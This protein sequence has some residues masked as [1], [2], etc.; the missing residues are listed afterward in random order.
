MKGKIKMKNIFQIIVESQKEN[1]E[2][3]K[4]NS[5][6]KNF[7][8]YKEYCENHIENVKKSFDFLK[9]NVPEI[10]QGLDL[11]LLEKNISEHDSSKFSEKE[12][13]GY[14]NKF[15]GNGDLD[16]FHKA[17][18]DHIHHSP[19]HWQYWV[20]VHDNGKDD[21]LIEMPKEYVIEM[22]CDWMSFSIAK[23][24][25]NELFEFY[26]NQKDIMRL[27]KKSKEFLE[28]CLNKIKEVI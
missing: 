25:L 6:V 8:S 26:K 16:E 10:I 3:M 17:F 5:P 23:D 22:I 9:E 21:T 20:L 12:I 2:Y 24:D 1:Y 7:S 14:E 18:L 13:K 19:H 11:E 4:K 27:N 28:D 15:F